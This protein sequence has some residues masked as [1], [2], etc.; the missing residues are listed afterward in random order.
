MLRGN[1]ATDQAECYD[2]DGVDVD[3]LV[4]MFCVHLGCPVPGG[5]Y[6]GH[7]GQVVWDE[8]RQPKV[9][10]LEDQIVDGHRLP[11]GHAG[12]SGGRPQLDEDVGRLQ[13]SG[14][15]RK[16]RWSH[17]SLSQNKETNT[18]P[19]ETL[20]LT[21]VGKEKLFALIDNL[22][23]MPSL[24]MKMVAKIMCLRM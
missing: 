19:K 2:A 6:V 7:G 16:L 17:A 12:D 3:G 9:P 13:I 23:K 10:H 1:P 15:Q 8:T 11:L 22:C 14:G 5:P 18:L 21:Y 4:V 20:Y 24:C